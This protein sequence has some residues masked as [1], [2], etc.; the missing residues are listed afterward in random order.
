MYLQTFENLLCIYRGW[1][2]VLFRARSPKFQKNVLYCGVLLRLSCA[3]ETCR[4]VL[5][6]F[7][8]K[9]GRL[10]RTHRSSITLKQYSLWFFVQNIFLYKWKVVA[11]NG[12]WIKQETRKPIIIYCWYIFFMPF[13]QHQ[14]FEYSCQENVITVQKKWKMEI[15]YQYNPH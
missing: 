14:M 11:V 8:P 4:T 6:L 3:K 15:F 2:Q 5:T 9:S 12:H 13:S 1:I 7:C 10:F